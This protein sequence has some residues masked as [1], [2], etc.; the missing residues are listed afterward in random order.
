M[1]SFTVSETQPTTTHRLT[2]ST[3][4]QGLRLDRFLHARLEH[5]S[6]SYLQQLIAQ[7]HASES[8]QTITSASAKVKPGTVYVLYI[9]PVQTL[10]LEPVAMTLHVVYEDAHLL[11]LNKPAGLAVHPAP[12]THGPTLVHGLLHHCAGQLSGIGGVARPGIVHRLD[13]DTSGLMVVAKTDAAHQHLSAQLKART[14]KRTYC[15]ICWGVP[16]PAQ[17]TIETQIGRHPK[18]RKKMAVLRE[19][20]KQARTHYETEETF[21]SAAHQPC[22][23]RVTCRLE[24][25]RTHQI[26]VHM[27]HIGYPLIG[28]ATYGPPTANQLIKHSISEGETHRFLLGYGRQALHAA[29]LTLIH[30]ALHTV[31]SFEAPLPEDMLDLLYHLNHLPDTH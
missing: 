16:A 22:A 11:V 26:R 29:R 23:S 12:G 5:L 6:R 14:L 2:A 21:P 15:A 17:G 7:G 28:D 19:G 25:G 24:T 10:T 4:D 30:P 13:K 27:L 9:P 18:D 1:T 3:A 8:G 20:G 31:M